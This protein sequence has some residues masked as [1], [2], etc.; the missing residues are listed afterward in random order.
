MIMIINK[1][2]LWCKKIQPFIV[3]DLEKM[4][5]ENDNSFVIFLCSDKLLK[6][7]LITYVSFKQ[8]INNVIGFLIS[9]L[10]LTIF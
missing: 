10:H 7:I 9:F 4:F 6:I 2:R 1:I 8:K 3:V 5:C